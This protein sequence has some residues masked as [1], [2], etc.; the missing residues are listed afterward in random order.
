MACTDSHPF[1]AIPFTIRILNPYIRESILNYIIPIPPAPPAG[2]AG[3]SSLIFATTDS[4][5]SKV[6]ATEVAFCNALLVTFTG[7]KMPADRKST[8]LN[9]SHM[10]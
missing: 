9:S 8:R 10:A 1:L 5:V 2:I 3:V 6:D 4:V 7:S